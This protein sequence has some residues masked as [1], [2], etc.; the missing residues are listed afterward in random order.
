MGAPGHVGVLGEASRRKRREGGGV[1]AGPCE[2]REQGR[3]LWAPLGTK[4]CGTIAL[5]C[6]IGYWVEYCAES[7]SGLFC[8][9]MCVISINDVYFSLC[10]FYIN[11]DNGM[12]IVL[13]LALSSHS[14]FDI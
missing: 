14:V 12:Y 6:S 10:G 2:T 4:V 13:Q 1:E 7:P 3:A 5:G 8:T 9:L 11:Y